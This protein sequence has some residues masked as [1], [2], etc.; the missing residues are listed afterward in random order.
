MNETITITKTRHEQLLRAENVARAFREDAARQTFSTRETALLALSGWLE[1][2][3]QEEN[4]NWPDVN[5]EMFCVSAMNTSQLEAILIADGVLAVG[6]VEF[7]RQRG[8]CESE[9]EKRLQ[10]IKKMGPASKKTNPGIWIVHDSEGSV[11]VPFDNE[12]DALRFAL[13]EGQSYINVK[14]VPFG[15]RLRDVK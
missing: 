4:D 3:G 12:L 1:I 8:D 10:A 14:L 9:I 7:W 2:A 13:A 5:R 15:K 11:I 6:Q